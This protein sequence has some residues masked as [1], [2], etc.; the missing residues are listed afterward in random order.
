VPKIPDAQDMLRWFVESDAGRRLI[1]DHEAQ[2]QS[3]R[4]QARA[5]IERLSSETQ[6]KLPELLKARQ[7][8]QKKFLAARQAYKSAALAFSAAQAEMTGTAAAYDAEASAQRRRL[9]DL[10]DGDAIDN[11][12]RELEGLHRACDG[13]V[14][15]NAHTEFDPETGGDLRVGN[16]NCDKVNARALAILR[17]IQTCQE[18]KWLGLAGAE[19]EARVQA[20]RESIPDAE[21]VFQPGGRLR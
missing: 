12:R 7:A 2:L 1:A 16:G 18:W 19:L 14:V 10:A 11:F 17:A 21:P 8:A 13:L 9:F 15:R 3:Q 5:E 4:D 20:L 6:A